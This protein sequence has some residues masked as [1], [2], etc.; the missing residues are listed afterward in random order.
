MST[1]NTF[2]DYVGDGS[3]TDFAV[4]FTYEVPADV[5]AT[6]NGVVT[7]YTFSNPSLI[8]ISPAPANGAAV[9][10]SRVTSLSSKR[11]VFANGSPTAAKQLNSA[12][13]QLY[14]SLQ[15]ALDRIEK[16]ENP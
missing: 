10:V 14:N 5:V 15:E 1:Y 8:Q 11:V 2:A 12:I 3:T 4:P 6:V 7:S 9:R 16:L 13:D